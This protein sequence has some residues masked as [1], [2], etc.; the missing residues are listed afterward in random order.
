MPRLPPP[1]YC[2]Q[3]LF[4]RMGSEES[5]TPSGAPAGGA[6]AAEAF[7]LGE[8][9]DKEKAEE[10]E[11]YAETEQSEKLRLQAEKLTLQV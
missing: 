6:T 10:K 7:P 1:P 9:G 5:P 8:G 3:L 2:L 4:C 11:V